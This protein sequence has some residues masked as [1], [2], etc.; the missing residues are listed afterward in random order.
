MQ[1]GVCMCIV[2]VQSLSQFWPFATPWTAAHQASWSITISM[3][4]L[5]PRLG[6]AIQPS[7][8]LSS[9]SPPDFN[10]SQHQGLFQWVSS[11]GGQSLGVSA[12]A[13]VLPMNTRDWSPLGWTGWIS[14]QSK[15]LSRVFSTS[16]VQKHRYL[17]CSAFLIVRPTSIHD[18]WTKEWLESW[19]I[20]CFMSFRMDVMLV[21]MNTMLNNTA[22]TALAMSGNILN[23]SS[24]FQQWV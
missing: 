12:S 6:D 7:H 20:P 9:P 16:T 14:L 24:R 13:S 23:L 5:K 15:R 18:Y 11:S 2:V 1:I 21:D 22:I 10:L 17:R 8:L 3:S 19:N 4:L